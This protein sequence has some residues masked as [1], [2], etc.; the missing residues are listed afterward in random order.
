[1]NMRQMYA[2][3]IFWGVWL[4][5]TAS[6]TTVSVKKNAT[7]T[8]FVDDQHQHVQPVM[9]KDGQVDAR[10]I[11]FSNQTSLTKFKIHSMI[12]GPNNDDP[13]EPNYEYVTDNMS[14]EETGHKKDKRQVTTARI[15]STIEDPNNDLATEA[16]NLYI[17]GAGDDNITSEEET[18]GHKKDKQQ[19][20]TPTINV[21]KCNVLC[22]KTTY[23]IVILVM[24]F[25]CIAFMVSTIIL[26]CK[27]AVSAD[28]KHGEVQQDHLICISAMTGETQPFAFDLVTGAALPEQSGSMHRMSLLNTRALV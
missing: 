4:H 3:A 9:N 14:E 1:M 22:S 12:E 6:T 25:I 19:V 18:I 7:P 11:H 15:N 5:V 20:T 10:N 17:T 26:G 13:T 27:V 28:T 2:V 23:A 24:T 21:E 8:T 16:N